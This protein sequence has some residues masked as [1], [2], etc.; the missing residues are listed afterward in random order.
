MKALATLEV[1]DLVFAE[2]I[3]WGG[4]GQDDEEGDKEEGVHLALRIPTS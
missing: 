3:P 1:A 4:D 2:A